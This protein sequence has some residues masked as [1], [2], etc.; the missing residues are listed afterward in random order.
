MQSKKLILENLNLINTRT[1][2]KINLLVVDA[3][4]GLFLFVFFLI[5]NKPYL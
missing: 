2:I 3:I 4:H 1:Q 5:S